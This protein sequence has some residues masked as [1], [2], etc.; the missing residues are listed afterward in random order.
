M[1]STCFAVKC[2]INID[3]F[4]ARC[5][6]ERVMEQNALLPLRVQTALPRQTLEPSLSLMKATRDL[7]QPSAKVSQ[8][9]SPQLQANG[10]SRSSL[11]KEM[12]L[13]GNLQR[14]RMMILRN[15]KRD[16]VHERFR[17]A[18]VL[19]SSRSSKNVE[20]CCACLNG[21]LTSL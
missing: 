15:V 9:K 19:P 7:H 14:E 2:P 12:H 5:A 18:P 13:S 4:S 1:A 11:D 8:H 16:A 20:L 6:R 3:S 17:E 21:P 10:S